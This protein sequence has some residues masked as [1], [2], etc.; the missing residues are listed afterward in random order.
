MHATKWLSLRLRAPIV[1][2]CRVFTRC[3]VSLCVLVLFLSGSLCVAAEFVPLAGA[4]S[5]PVYLVAQ[6]KVDKSPKSVSS[7]AVKNAKSPSKKQAKKTSVSR[8][9]KVSSAPALQADQPNDTAFDRPGASA[10]A[11]GRASIPVAISRGEASFMS[12]KLNGRR[13]ASGEVYRKNRFT[14]AHRTLP[15]GTVVQVTDL[16]NGETVVVRINDRGPYAS[17]RIL[18]VS[19]AA[20]ERLGMIGLGVTPVQIDV[21]SDANGRPLLPKNSFFLSFGKQDAIDPAQVNQSIPA[22]ER[23]LLPEAKAMQLHSAQKNG[24]YTVMGPFKR[25]TDAHAV[26]DRLPKKLVPRIVYAAVP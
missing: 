13:T 18:D 2:C 25:F 23:A 4:N 21:V 12:N 6:K 15:L 14:A 22:A 19:Y 7:K 11:A 1:A 3:V 8:P 26:L 10:Q 24:T 20:A 17:N 9:Q 5:P 16:N